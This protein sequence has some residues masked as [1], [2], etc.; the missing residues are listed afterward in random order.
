VSDRSAKL[1]FP[2]PGT[3]RE[4]LTH[5][6][7]TNRRAEHSAPQTLGSPGDPTARL[8]VLQGKLTFE[9]R[10]STQLRLSVRFPPAAVRVKIFIDDEL[11]KWRVTSF[12]C[13][14]WKQGL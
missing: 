2:H 9:S 13:R 10:K 7:N 3:L 11:G 6:H 12:R 4:R 8:A 14:R 1:V 5:A